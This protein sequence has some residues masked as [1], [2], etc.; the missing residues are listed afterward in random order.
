MGFSFLVLPLQAAAWQVG[1]HCGR[2]FVN[3]EISFD[4]SRS[5]RYGNKR[6]DNT[7]VVNTER[8]HCIFSSPVL[9]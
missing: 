9:F 1:K 7:G 6:Q 5:E 3:G 8:F 4:R 2:L